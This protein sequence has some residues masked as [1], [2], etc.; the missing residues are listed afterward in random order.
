MN[1][2]PT[3]VVREYSN[4]VSRYGAD[5]PQAL[6]VH[7][8]YAAV[9][10][11]VPF[12]AALAEIKRH[13]G[14]SGVDYEPDAEPSLEA[15]W[16]S[17]SLLEARVFARVGDGCVVDYSA[18]ELD[19]NDLAIDNLDEVAVEGKVRFRAGRDKFW[20]GKA[21]QDWESPVLENPTWLDLCVHANAMILATND[22]HHCFLEGVEITGQDGDV[23]LAEFSM[24]S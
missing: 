16:A 18:Y 22:H 15:E 23:K 3:H 14:G 24:G 11:F 1:D 7:A 10:G 9:K 4:A 19:K 2:V 6:E 13:V 12:A 8:K 20:G 21:S 17:M 5:S